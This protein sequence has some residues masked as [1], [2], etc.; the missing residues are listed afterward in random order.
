MKTKSVLLLSTLA[1]AALLLIAAFAILSIVVQF[2]NPPVARGQCEDAYEPDDTYTTTVTVTV[3]SFTS[4]NFHDAGD[5]DWAKFWGTVG[6]T[7]TVETLNLADNVDTKVYLYSWNGITLTELARDDDGGPGLAS[8][9]IQ[10]MPSTGWYYVESG[11]FTSGDYGCNATYDLSIILT[12]VPCTTTLTIEPNTLVV[13]DTATMIATVV[14]CSGHPLAGKV[15][16]FSTTSDLGSGGISPQTGTSNSIGRVTSSISSTI[17]GTKLVVATAPNGVTG[18]A[19]VTFIA[20]A[21]APP[22]P[23]VY[24]PTILKDYSSSEPP[25]APAPPPDCPIVGATVGVGDEPHGVAIITTTNRIYVA[26]R[27]S[28]SVSVIDGSTHSV[29]DTIDLSSY[30]SSPS[31]IAYHP[32]GFLYVSLADSDKVAVINASTEAVETVDVGD[33]PAGVAVN[34]VSGKVYVANFGGAS[35]VTDTVSVISGTTVVGTIGV[36]DAPS[37]IAVN[38]VTN[39]IF[40]TNHGHGTNYGEEGSSVSVINGSTDTV[41]PTI[42]L[43]LDVSEPGEGPHGI[44]VNPNTNKI[45]VAVIDSHQLVVIDGNDLDARPTYIAPSPDV[46]IWMVAVNPDLN[47]VYAAGYNE[48]SGHNKVLALDG[49]TNTWLTDLDVGTHPKQGM[50]YNP[51]T[52]LL[53]VSNEGSDNVTVIWTCSASESPSTPTPTPT[54]TSTS[55]PT[56]TPTGSTTPTATPTAT[57]TPTSTPTANPTATDTTPPSDCYPTVEAPITVGN[58]PRG[59]AYNADDNAIYVA[60]YGDN[61]VSVVSGVSYD[62][63]KVITGVVGDNGVAYDSDHGLVY[64]TNQSIDTLTVI[65]TTTNTIVETIPVG[66]QPHGVAYNH[67]PISH[68]VYVANYGDNTVTIIDANTMTTT[69]TIT[70]TAGLDQPAHIAVNPDTNKVYVSNHGNGTV[71]VIHGNNDTV[72]ATVSLDSSGPYGIAA[73]TERNLIYV[74]STEVADRDAANLVTIDG[75]TDEVKPPPWGR[76]N[77]HKTDD[78]LVPL[79]VIAVNPYL[80]PS[81][82]GG[83]LYI[84]SSSGDV[85]GDGSPGTDQLLMI[86]KGWEDGF[87]RPN[88]LDVGSRP[89]EG[90]AVDLDHNRVFVTARDANQLTIIQDTADDDQL[91]FETFG[92]D[93]YVIEPVP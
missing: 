73:D 1:S 37:Q 81:F 10:V 93:G 84:T 71:T 16:T 9:I 62:V 74:V 40:V 8:R 51:E 63:T 61:T 24:L 5:V 90:V 89:E 45:Y 17:T 6:I 87:N 54:A 80:G 88:P 56:A 70:E 31:G 66:D 64:V 92:L 32:S 23:D 39:R 34:P 78:S 44:A 12:D 28:N 43:V 20:P 38:P 59:V 3:P 79:R 29:I 7:Y 68:R 46:M 36:G 67:N 91:C 57:A 11:R 76:V 49:A 85:A 42:P 25:P 72:L 50:A 58:D 75:A 33:N 18:T 27:G 2:T 52:G 53:Y 77:I 65:S 4:H 82:G 14:D 30:G 55:T 26:N 19:T 69:E 83:H 41:T 48:V 47:R 21:P 22:S 60:N 86:R 13:S 35:T 15:I